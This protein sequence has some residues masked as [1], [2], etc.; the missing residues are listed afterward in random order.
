M[1]SLLVQVKEIKNVDSLNIVTF[2]F[3]G[4]ELKMMSLE[5]KENIKKGVK[6]ILNTKPTSVAIAK[7]FNGLISFSNHL[8]GKVVEIQKGELLCNLKVSIAS[9]IFESIITVDSAKRL[10]LKIDDEVSVFIKAS[11]LSISEVIDG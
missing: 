4:N 2:D 8:K 7:E 11:D 6:V 5:L 1:S 3:Y 9:S 10:D